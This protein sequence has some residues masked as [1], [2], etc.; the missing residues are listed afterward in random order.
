MRQIPPS[1]P[2]GEVDSASSHLAAFIWKWTL[3]VGT[4][5][6]YPKTWLQRVKA[7]PSSPHL[8]LVCELPQDGGWEN[9]GSV[10]L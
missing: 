9:G 2:L 6:V 4:P 8:A 3:E 10:A 7:A 1:Y 5:L